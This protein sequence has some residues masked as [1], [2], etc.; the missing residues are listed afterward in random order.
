VEKTGTWK[1][2]ESINIPLDAIFGEY[3]VKVSDGRSQIIKKWN[4]ETNKIIIIN[5]EKIKF[6]AGELITFTGTAMPNTPLELV[7][8]NNVGDEISSDILQHYL[9]FLKHSSHSFQIYVFSHS[10]I[11]WQYCLNI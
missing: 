10:D 9:F 11:F 7:L 5:P 4:V 1:L 6:D 2:S 8:K 3:T